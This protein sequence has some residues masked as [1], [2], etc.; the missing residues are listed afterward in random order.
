MK[1][2]FVCKAMCTHACIQC[3]ARISV[4]LDILMKNHTVNPA[5]VYRYVYPL[6]TQPDISHEWDFWLK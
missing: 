2:F 1:I 6:G 3:P 4:F 5:N